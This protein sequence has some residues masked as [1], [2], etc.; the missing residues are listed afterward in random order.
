MSVSSRMA[1]MVSRSYSPRA[2]MR[3]TRVRSVGAPAIVLLRVERMWPCRQGRLHAGSV[4][5]F[6]ACARRGRLLGGAF[7][8]A[9]LGLAAAAALVAVLLH[10]A[11][12]VVGQH[13][14]GVPHVG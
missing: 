1:S 3:R 4:G 14:D 12:E 11:G 9:L 10:L 8:S 13:V 7:L 6:G 5:R 2:G